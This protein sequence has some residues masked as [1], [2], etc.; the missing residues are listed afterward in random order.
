MDETIQR[1]LR[2]LPSVSSLLESPEVARAGATIR[3]EIVA[4]LARKR[5]ESA[6]ARILRGDTSAVETI[7]TD[8][9]ADLEGLQQPTTAPVIN[10]TGII[11]HT[12]LGRAPVSEAT[13]TAMQRVASSNVALEVDPVT[14]R[15]GGRGREVAALI[16]ALTGCEDALIVNNNAAAITL[17]LHA[18]A[19]D[20]RVVVSRGEA[21]EIGGGF[22]IPDVLRQS[23]CV[24]AEVGTTNRTYLRDYASAID[25]NTAALMKIHASNFAILGFS[26]QPSTSEV[27]DLAR[28]HG[29]YAIEDA[30]SGCLV[31]TE[32]YGLGPEPLLQDSIESGVHVVTASGD[33]LLG[34]PQAGLILGDRETIDTI[35][36]HPLARAVRVDKTVQAGIAETLRHYVTGTHEEEIPVWWSISRS[37]SWLASRVESWM[38]ALDNHPALE[39]IA[40]ESAV[41]GGSLPGKTLPSHALA[42]R[43]PARDA[44]SVATS[45]RTG[46]PSVFARIVDDAVVIDARTVLRHQDDDLIEALRALLS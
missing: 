30:G 35:R 9:L 34:G 32:P 12:N 11:V 16:R 18:L 25:E 21:V 42:V 15:R 6:R 45:L 26:H 43:D 17:T 31:S 19:S 27:A 36:S 29:I 4:D 39:S 14:G 3:A 8:L 1:T 33:K 20:R 41:G 23:G 40:S 28:E 37:P 13:A 7:V 44:D 38:Q 5:Q 24:L 22:R 2:S 46:R 10:G